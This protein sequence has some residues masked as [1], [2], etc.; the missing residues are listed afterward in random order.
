[1]P[2]AKVLLV[3]IPPREPANIDTLVHNYNKLIARFA[4]HK[5]VHFLDLA[6]HFETSLGH[7]HAELFLPDHA[8]FTAKGYE[9]WY[10]IMEPTFNA[11][12]L[13]H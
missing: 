2:N 1:M 10:K 5:R 13:G 11:L 6:V 7:E 8:H 4:D 12:Y 3:S 9:L